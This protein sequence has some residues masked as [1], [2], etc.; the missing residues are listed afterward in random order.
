MAFDKAVSLLSP[1]GSS[2]VQCYRTEC[3]SWRKEFR[4]ITRNSNSYLCSSLNQ[5]LT[6]LSTV[7]NFGM[8]ILHVFINQLLHFS[9]FTSIC[10]REATDVFFGSSINI[11]PAPKDWTASLNLSIVRSDNLVTTQRLVN[12][13]EVMGRAS[14]F[15]S[16]LREPG[17]EIHVNPF[18]I[19]KDILWVQSNQPL[20]WRELYKLI[21]QCAHID[22]QFT[23]TALILPSKFSRASYQV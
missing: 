13:S 2:K 9:F 17:T 8:A 18:S 19:I 7:V 5:Y 16:E 23:W 10:S 4:L 14:M 20:I 6:K 21:G 3:D 1:L 11:A 15:T 22:R 12:M